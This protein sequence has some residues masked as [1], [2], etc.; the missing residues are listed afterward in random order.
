MRWVVKILRPILFPLVLC[1]FLETSVWGLQIAPDHPYPG[2]VILLKGVP[3]Q[4]GF[5]KMWGKRFGVFE[6]SRKRMCLLPVPLGTPPGIYT[7]FI[8]SQRRKIRVY[9]K[10]YPEEHLTVA[11]NMVSYTPE[12][13]ARVKREICL[14]K[15]KVAPFR[16]YNFIDGPFVWPLNTRITSPF[17]LRRFF[18][19][20]P[21]SPHGGIDLAAPRGTPV[22]AANAGHIVLARHLYLPGNTI[23]IDHGLGIYTIYAHLSRFLVHEGDMVKRGQIIALSGATGRVTGPHLHF[24]CYIEGIKIDPQSLLDLLGVAWNSSSKRP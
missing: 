11:S 8:G 22:R 13:L 15:K 16:P 7:L 1:I 6:L 24:G 20:K 19:G 14:I 4:V 2:G 10:R 9:A 21:R 3:K 23:I 5:V 18:N 17:G 12:I